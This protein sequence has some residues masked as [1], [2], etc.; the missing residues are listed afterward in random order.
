MGLLNF[1]WRLIFGDPPSRPESSS[2]ASRDSSVS[3]NP[4]TPRTRTRKLRARL[5][6][7]R[8]KRSRQDFP[9][10]I[11]SSL[12]Y[13]FARLNV[14][15]G[16]LDL[17]QDL[18][19]P[20]L[21]QLGL[22]LLATPEQLA[23]WLGIPLG[24]LAWLTHR[25][26]EG[27]RPRDVRHSHYH[28]RWV[29]KKQ[30]GYRLIEAPKHQLRRLQD[31]ILLEILC[32]IPVHPAAHGFVAGRSIRSNA[33]PHVGQR[34]VVK[35]DLANFYPTVRFSR[36]V[37]IFRAI[38]FSREVAIWLARI[39]T[40]AVPL[41]FEGPPGELNRWALTPYY[42]RHL[43]QGA[44]TSPALANLSAY[45]LDRRL[46][47]LAR[48]FRAN[49]TRYADDLTFSG[50]AKF[51]SGLRNFV[52]LVHTVIRRERFQ[53]HYKKT[54]VHRSNQ[55]QR[56][57]GVVVNE[58]PNMSRADFDRLK[59]ILTN[60]IRRGVSTQNHSQ[61]PDFEAHL[62]GKISHAKFLNPA[63]GAKLLALL[64]KIDWQS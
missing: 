55:H 61:I 45:L 59:A 23:N 12:P 52:P 19:E 53:L 60:C 2:S 43:P 11:V 50:D 9:Q 44:P 17:S 3:R 20:Q 28:Y 64:R 34:V 57:T 25:C 29:K 26:D 21:Q 27:Q 47:G 4:S 18:D 46:A 1:F 54:K 35:M 5:I 63:R 30:G 14:T 6:P 15:G 22:P 24:K 58:K 48:R 31:K 41:A 51:L 8:V 40:S 56:V 16:Y 10:N 13:R 38:G 32:K 36:V 37:S 62:R 33:E 7:D 49:Y 39:T 42:S